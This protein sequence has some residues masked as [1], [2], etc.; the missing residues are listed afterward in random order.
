MADETL[1]TSLFV[2]AS[3]IVTDES[4][5][6]ICWKP[7]RVQDEYPHRRVRAEVSSRASL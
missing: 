2:V 1:Q 6:G 4:G 3:A 5:D 7:L